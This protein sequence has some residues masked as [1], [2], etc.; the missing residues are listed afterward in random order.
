[1]APRMRPNDG[2]VIPNFINQALKNEDITIYGDGSQ[3]RSFCLLLTLLQQCIEYYLV[4]TRRHLILEIQTN[5][6]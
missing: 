6:P 3:T 5:T 1:M 4:M 2:R